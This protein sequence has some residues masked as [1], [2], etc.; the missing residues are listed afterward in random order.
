MH[1]SVNNPGQSTQGQSRPSV[2]QS[3]SKSA[4][5]RSQL[6]QTQGQRLAPQKAPDGYARRDGL[7]TALGWFSIGLGV[8][9][10]LAPRSVSR[11]TGIQESPALMRTIGLREITA[12]V[13]IL[14]Q[15]NRAGWLWTRVA[16]DIMDLTLLGRA[17]H[18]PSGGRNRAA[19]AAAAVTG[20][21]VLDLLSSAQHA[22]ADGGLL[23]GPVSVDKVITI[24]RSA[25][26]CYR[27]WRNFE[28]FPRFMKHLESVQII[29]DRRSHWKAKAPAGTSVEWDA[30]LTVDQPGQLLAWHSAQGADIANGGTVGFERAA[31]GRGTIVHVH[32]QYNPPGGQAGALIAKLFGE[33]PA[34]QIDED[35]RRFKQL[36]ETG[37]VATTLGQPSGP[38]SALVR[39]MHRGEQK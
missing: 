6:Q 12:G 33:E 28:N 37:E 34:R 23:T 25:E 26:E 2:R 1:S 36:I 22:S 17:R 13:G 32:L 30:E 3:Q 10:L 7:A 16:G 29:D 39:L 27:F 9:Q 11:M 35:L 15:R 18:L 31:G 19:I 24:N 38:R 21:A 4:Q 20:V 8:A 14:S 5:S